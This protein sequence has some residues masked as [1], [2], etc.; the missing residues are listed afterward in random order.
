LRYT[1][2]IFI[3]FILGLCTQ[4]SNTRKVAV[5]Q[6]V[7]N[8]N[9]RYN[10]YFNV[11][12]KY[13]TS[14]NSAKSEIK[15]NFD[16]LIPIFEYENNPEVF[17]AKQDFNVMDEKMSK[18]IFRFP[19][20]RW[21]DDGLF[22]IGKAAYLKGDYKKA[23]KT[24][25]YITS[26][27]KNGYITPEV[28]T[29]YKKPP[30]KELKI[31]EAEKKNIPITEG[32]F[33]HTKSRNPAMIW[34][35]KSYI[36]SEQ[37]TEAQSI[38]SYAESDMTFPLEKRLELQKVQSMLY[39][40]RKQYASAIASLKVLIKDTKNKKQKSRYNY[41][42]G[43]ISEI[44]HQ[45]DS[46]FLFY[47]AV[48]K[49]NPTDLM[50][51]NTKL[52][53]ARLASK[54]NSN[55]ALEIL[56][57]MAKE[58]KNEEFLDII[59]YEIAEVYI[60]K[61]ME[62]EGISFYQKSIKAHT[63]NK[64]QLALTNLK[65]GQYYLQKE[66]YKK[67]EPN[68]DS[69]V[70]AMAQSSPI[71]SQTR[72]YASGLKKINQ[73]YDVINDVDKSNELVAMGKD[74]ALKK[75]LSELR[76][77]RKEKETK[78]A[79]KKYMSSKKVN[80]IT[81]TGTDK[82][83]FG[84][85]NLMVSGQLEFAKIWGTRKLENNWR[86]SNKIEEKTEVDPNDTST[87]K[88]EVIADEVSVEAEAEAKIKSLPFDSASKAQNTKNAVNSYYV[89]GN[90][91]KN[92]MENYPKAILVFEEMNQ[93]YPNHSL[94][95]ESYYNLYYVSKLAGDNAKSEKYKQLLIAKFPEHKL[96]KAMLNPAPIKPAKP[97][98]ITEER[99]YAATYDGFQE[100][101]FDETIERYKAYQPQYPA[102]VYKD[103]MSLLNAMSLG[104][105]FDYEPFT[106]E[107]NILANNAKDEV[108]KKIAMDQLA[109]YLNAGLKKIP[110]AT[111][112]IDTTVKTEI[113]YNLKEDQLSTVGKIDTSKKVISSTTNTIDTTKNVAPIKVTY[114]VDMNAEHAFIYYVSKDN[115]LTE[116]SNA[117]G[118]YNTKNFSSL[119]LKSNSVKIA[120]ENVNMLQPLS[121]GK[122]A[123]FYL[124]FILMEKGIFDVIRPEEYKA[125]II[126]LDNL[127]LLLQS[128]A[129]ELY[130]TF[131]KENYK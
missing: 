106:K 72:T 52:K 118:N 105:K 31:K 99:Y 101:K 89:L 119:N 65:L 37:Y 15:E 113:K 125:Y 5:F 71:I 124:K 131:Y 74:A 104:R 67:A 53:I 102:K 128:N 81:L 54:S 34:L 95:P 111:N 41:I 17:N 83:Y 6:T 3:F 98:S 33:E 46:A 44:N 1:N 62:K 8:F 115:K 24:F 28:R 40:E 116:I 19:S 78:D 123:G 23:I 110:T 66:D 114:K 58:S 93:K 94:L 14:F 100:N 43:Q 29:K 75:I 39:L 51:F 35:A 88:T 129:L 20:S 45:D 21:A 73:S 13:R 30:R 18:L 64:N 120:N 60:R 108:V 4:C 2:L 49:N 9:S 59:Y 91:F 38:I 68:Y 79:E 70:V 130:D 56:F 109:K 84:N 12:D 122:K 7:H 96:T 69:A 87:K 47:S 107:M 121:D 11:N 57:K 127:T 36:K 22:L 32:F 16:T 97:D 86:R 61:K 90:A 117:V 50:E 26:E 63:V 80:D 126:S 48:L 10:T 25:E 112:G 92:E 42:L 76:A 55:D 77:T 103:K 27:Y 82:W 85:M